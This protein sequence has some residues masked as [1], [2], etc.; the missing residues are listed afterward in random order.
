MNNNNKKKKTNPKLHCLRLKK[1]LLINRNYLKH[2]KNHI[3]I[4]FFICLVNANAFFVI[5]V[6]ANVIME[7]EIK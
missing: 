1:K 7:K 6:N 2:L 4:I 5:V 3:R